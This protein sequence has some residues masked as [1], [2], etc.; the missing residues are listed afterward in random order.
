LRSGDGSARGWHF[1]GHPQLEALL[2]RIAWRR[3]ADRYQKHGRAIARERSLDEAP[4][5]SLLDHAQAR[6]SQIAQGRE[7]WDGVLHACPK[8]HHEVVR[9]RMHGHRI[10][11]IAARTSMH[12]GS[13][14]RILYELARKL[15]IVRRPAP[16]DDPA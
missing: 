14:R 2:H 6:P 3:L 5:Q 4:S 10:T 7:F 11:E 16:T 15:S 12:E 13:V 9:L 8:A 1:A